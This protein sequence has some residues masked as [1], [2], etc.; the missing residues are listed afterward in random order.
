M[1]KETQP[2]GTLAVLIVYL[3]ITIASWVGVYLLMVQR[4]G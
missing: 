1:Q 3:I 2:R 4:G